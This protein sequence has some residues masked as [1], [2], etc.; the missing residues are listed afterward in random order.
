MN[1]AE[2]QEASLTPPPFLSLFPFL[3]DRRKQPS[4]AILTT[5]Y[6]AFYKSRFNN[7]LAGGVESI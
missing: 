2:P 4:A 3:T 5:T 6:C 1:R 7:S